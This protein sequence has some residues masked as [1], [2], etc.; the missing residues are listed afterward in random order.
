MAATV[1]LVEA[2]HFRMALQDQE[3]SAKETRAVMPMVAEVVLLV[4]A[5]AVL[6]VWVLQ[7]TLLRDKVDQALQL[8]SLDLQSRMQVVAA[9]VVGR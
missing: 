7:E 6:V 3:L 9:V 4:V 1:V 5:A 2:V 8:L